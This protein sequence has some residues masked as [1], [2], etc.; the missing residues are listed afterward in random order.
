MQSPGA[1]SYCYVPRD[2]LYH[3][4]AQANGH[5]ETHQTTRLHV[6]HLT[7]NVSEG[8]IKE[9]FSTFGTITSVEVS[10]DKVGPQTSTPWFRAPDF[11]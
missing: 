8:H 9:I 11:A 5:A 2:V 3:M 7:R 1:G 6:G 4:Q 10:I